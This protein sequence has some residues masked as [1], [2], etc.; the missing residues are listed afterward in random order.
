MKSE[1]HAGTRPWTSK[2]VAWLRA[3]GSMGREAVAESLGR[4][5][6]SVRDAAARHRVSLR[7]PGCNCGLIL[8]Q[9]RG[10]SLRADLRDDL[11]SGRID[12]ELLARR[13]RTDEA[14]ALCPS[15]GRRLARVVATGKCRKCTVDALIEAHLEALEEI[16]CEKA[17][18][19]SRS[20]L[21][22]ARRRNLKSTSSEE[23]CQT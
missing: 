10:V 4:S 18:W 23:S 6:A 12:P 16:D 5:I 20:A 15:C 17:L 1:H 22:R 8:G 3:N 19:A 13:M 21:Q 11:A 2:E 14:L 9:P 7:R